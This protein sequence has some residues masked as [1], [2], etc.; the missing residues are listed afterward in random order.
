MYPYSC[1][2]D[3]RILRI[4]SITY[5]KSLFKVDFLKPGNLE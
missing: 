4:S 3:L 5:K 1:N 2:Y